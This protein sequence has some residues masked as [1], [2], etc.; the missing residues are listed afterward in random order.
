MSMK[1]T[2]RSGSAAS[3]VSELSAT[4]SSSRLLRGRDLGEKREELVRMPL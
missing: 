2:V 3:R 4:R 1:M